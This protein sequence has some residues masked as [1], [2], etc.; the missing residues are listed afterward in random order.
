MNLVTSSDTSGTGFPTPAN[1]HQ[2]PNVVPGVNPILPNFNPVTGYFNPLAFQ[3]PATGTFGD[4]GRYALY[5]PGFWQIDFSLLK[6]TKITERVA[7]QFRAEFY[8]LLNNRTYSG[9]PRVMQFAL[10]LSF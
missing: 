4:L 5:G 3:Q 6:T 7:V 10:K 1:G 9:G 2:R 8:N